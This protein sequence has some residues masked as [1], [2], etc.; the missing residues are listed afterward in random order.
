MATNPF[1]SSAVLDSV[2][3]T[4]QVS[5]SVDEVLIP[6]KSGNLTKVA[7]LAIICLIEWSARLAQDSN[8]S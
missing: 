8:R 4:K 7:I 5:T 3:S 6:H 2:F 1:Q